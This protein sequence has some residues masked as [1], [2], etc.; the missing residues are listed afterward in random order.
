MLLICFLL[1]YL[2]QNQPFAGRV[3]SISD[4]DTFKVLYEGREVKIRLEH[5]DCPEKRQPFGTRA[6]QEVS[7]LIFGKNVIIRPTGKDRYG[8]ILAEVYADNRNVNKTLV[9]RGYAWHFKKYSSDAD[10]ARLERQARK[11]RLGLWQEQRPIP[12]WEWRKSRRR[13]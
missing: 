8:R 3:V 1:S 12:P 13:N 2:T 9:Q 5:I 4:G 6:R 7:R 11:S 10:Y